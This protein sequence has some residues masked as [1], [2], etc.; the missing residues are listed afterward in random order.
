MYFIYVIRYLMILVNV[1]N[2]VMTE[3]MI[4]Y[5]E[6]CYLVKRLGIQFTAFYRPNS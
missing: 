1:M 4:S 5:R 2:L 3:C 6:V